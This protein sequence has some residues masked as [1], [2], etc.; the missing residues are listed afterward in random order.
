MQT[1]HLAGRRC[2]IQSIPQSRRNIGELEDAV[3]GGAITTGQ[4]TVFRC[5]IHL[6]NSAATVQLDDSRIKQIQ[7]S[8]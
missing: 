7:Y 8:A 1:A 4:Q 6:E 5:C 2:L 3:A